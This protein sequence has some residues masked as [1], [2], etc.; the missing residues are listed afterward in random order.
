MP[1]DGIA[2]ALSKLGQASES[3]KFAGPSLIDYC[4]RIPLFEEPQEEFQLI[5]ERFSRM[6]CNGC[7]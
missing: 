5:R 7:D 2:M 6:A 4:T 1:K 3:L